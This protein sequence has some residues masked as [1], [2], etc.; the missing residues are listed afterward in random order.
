MLIPKAGRDGHR[1]PAEVEEPPRPGMN[2]T[3]AIDPAGLARIPPHPGATE[4]GVAV[5]ACAGSH[6]EP[7]YGHLVGEGCPKFRVREASGEMV[8]EGDLAG[9]LTL[10]VF[11]PFAFT[12]I[13]DA[14]LT[15][16]DSR[17]REF[18]DVAILAISCDPPAAVRAF[19]EQEDFAFEM[20]SDFWPH[21]R[22]LRRSACS[23]PRPAPLSASFVLS[24][25]ARFC[26]GST[27]GRPGPCR[28]TS[29]RCPAPRKARMTRRGSIRICPIHST[30]AHRDRPPRGALPHECGEGELL[31]AFRTPSPRVRVPETDLRTRD[32]EVFAFHDADL[33]APSEG[34]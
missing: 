11:Y 21:G 33:A 9:V 20:A 29:T 14:E 32:G 22:R 25:A 6:G 19:Q 23:T 5:S 4:T 17:I 12:P 1:A 34:R 10:L 13:C 8:G 7:R 15:E 31:E 3:N 18:D 30:R 24:P 16:L 2:T 28:P 27:C 26:V